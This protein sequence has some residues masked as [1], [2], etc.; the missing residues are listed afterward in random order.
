MHK[1]ATLPG[2]TF[3]MFA[4]MGGFSSAS[5]PKLVIDGKRNLTKSSAGKMAIA[6]KLNKKATD[7]FHTIVEFSQA[8]ALETKSKFLQKID[9]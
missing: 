7:Y 9:A 3:D 4:K 6:L 2:F 1:K 8:K 5:F